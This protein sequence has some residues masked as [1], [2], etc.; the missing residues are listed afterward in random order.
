MGQHVQ[1]LSESPC[2]RY[3]AKDGDSP[4][5][6]RSGLTSA[7]VPPVASRLRSSL[8]GLRLWLR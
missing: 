2:S 8:S 3:C 4:L 6:W 7:W 5:K 1:D